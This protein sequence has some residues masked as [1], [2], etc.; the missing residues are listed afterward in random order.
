MNDLVI[1][2]GGPAAYT[3]AIYAGRANLSP[4]VIESKSPGGQPAM[5]TLVE[6]FP[7]FPEGVQ[8]PE[9][10]K[11]MREQAKRFGAEF[12][13][14]DVSSVDFK[15]NHLK[16]II[17][18]EKEPERARAV[19]IATG[20]RPRK[21]G[22]PGEERL[23]GRGVCIC[24]TCDGPFFKNKEVAVIGGGDVALEEALF[25][26]QFAK[27]VTIIHRRDCLR[28]SKIMQD[29]A[30]TNEKIAFKWNTLIEEVIGE[31]K[32]QGLKLRDLKTN[33]LQSFACDGV[34]LALGREPSTE[35]L[36]NQLALDEKGYIKVEEGGAQTSIEG[37]F[38]AG[39]CVDQK[40]RQT[41]T[42]AGMGCM[43]ALEAE[44]YLPSCCN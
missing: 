26:V 37:V 17:D 33:E 32:V 38:A 11:R 28:A 4:L 42:A 30:Q 21:L 12:I 22:V 41:I 3:A 29:R 1:I 23:L 14:E 18:K 40:Y 15:T 6:N 43:A 16:I 20:A 36:K 13:T 35:F 10:V 27:K 19:I 8:G 25:L 2:G 5:T 7:G 34:F 39:D 24:A 31:K 44:R 9:L